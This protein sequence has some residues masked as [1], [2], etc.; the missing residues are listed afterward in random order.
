MTKSDSPDDVA[1][2][3]ALLRP[4]S[5]SCILLSATVG[6]LQWDGVENKSSVAIYAGGAVVLLWL[7]STIVSAVNG[8][9]LVSIQLVM[10]S[11]DQKLFIAPNS[12]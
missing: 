10:M 8:V 2:K 3:A 11:G 4:G 6:I 1:G 9:P 7:S 5:C 12:R